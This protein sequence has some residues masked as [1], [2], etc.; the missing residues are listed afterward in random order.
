MVRRAKEENTPLIPIRLVNVKA[1]IPANRG[2]IVISGNNQ[3]HGV[4]GRFASHVL[5]CSRMG[6]FLAGNNAVS[7]HDQPS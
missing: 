6:L 2:K 1:C 7:I 4:I 3:H 5:Q